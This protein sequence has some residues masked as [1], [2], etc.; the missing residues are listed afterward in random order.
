MDNLL[1][2]NNCRPKAIFA[3]DWGLSIGVGT[4]KL[5]LKSC[6]ELQRRMRNPR[7]IIA[8]RNAKSLLI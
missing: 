1:S 3:K 2:K 6:P 5:A 8:A 4:A 7:M